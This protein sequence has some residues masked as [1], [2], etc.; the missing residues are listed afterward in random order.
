MSPANVLRM[1]LQQ[2]QKGLKGK[3][4]VKDKT[5]LST[6]KLIPTSEKK[7]TLEKESGSIVVMEKTL[8]TT[9]RPH[10]PTQT[11]SPIIS[12]VDPPAAVVVENVDPMSDAYTVSHQTTMKW[13]LLDSTIKRL[14]VI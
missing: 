14:R 13:S 2:P 4:L 5:P 6:K 10:V 7:K 3:R 8:D 1:P 12:N 9:S 11:S